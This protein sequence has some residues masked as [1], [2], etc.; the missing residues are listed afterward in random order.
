ML[1]SCLRESTQSFGDIAIW[2]ASLT[3]LSRVHPFP[4]H[5]ESDCPS[6][7][8][9]SAI[10]FCT[11]TQGH[12]NEHGMGE[13]IMGRT[14]A[15][16]RAFLISSVVGGV[17]RNHFAAGRL[18]FS[19]CTGVLLCGAAGVLRGRQATTHWAAWNLLPYYGAIPVRSRV[20]RT[21]T[22]SPPRA[23]P[24]DLMLRW[25]SRRCWVETPS[26]RKFN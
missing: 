25:L 11:R 22:W 12:C 15:S 21:A 20:V 19:V 5:S 10:I 18:L 1:H 4:K 17:I 23:L 14:V 16:E 7:L 26:P 13:G 2:K 9:H 3:I 8:R 24:P 6:A